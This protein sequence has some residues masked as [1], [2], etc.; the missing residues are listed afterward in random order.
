MN[1][2][3]QYVENV[4]KA[5]LK[6]NI[7]PLRQDI[8]KALV[9]KKITNWSERYGYEYSEV[10]SKILTDDMFVAFSPRTPLNKTTQK[11]WQRNCFKLSIYL[12]MPFLFLKMVIFAKLAPRLIASLQILLRMMYTSLKNIL[13]AKV[14]HKTINI[15]M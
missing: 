2:F 5:R 9:Q 3:E 8:K 7:I 6:E 14:A 11:R 12:I 10:E 4:R 15:A 13:V 1:K